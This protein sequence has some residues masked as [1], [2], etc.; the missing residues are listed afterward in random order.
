MKKRFFLLTIL[1]ALLGIGQAWANTAA[2]NKSGSDVTDGKIV[3]SGNHA[4][5]TMTAE[6]HTIEYVGG[7]THHYSLGNLNKKGTSSRNCIFT[8]QAE[9]GCSIKVT[10]M[11]FGVRGYTPA[12][13]YTGRMKAKFNGNEKSVGNIGTS[14][15]FFDES[16]AEGFDN[17]SVLQIW[18]TESDYD[19]W[20]GEISITY[21][22]TPIDA[23]SVVEPATE[24]VIVSLP[25][26][27]NYVDLTNAFAFANAVPSDFAL[28]YDKSGGV[29]EGTNF[30]ATEAGEYTVKARVAAKENCHEA[31]AWSSDALTITVNR[32]D[33]TL[34]WVDE[35]AINTNMIV[36]AEQKI[37]A[38][39]TSG[40]AVTY[41]SSNTDVMTV[42]AEGNLK[43]VAV[44]E[45]VITASRA[46]DDQYN[47]A[48]PITKTFKVRLKDTPFFLPVDFA[49]ADSCAVPVNEEAAIELSYVS[50]GLDGDFTATP[51]D[52]NVISVSRDGNRLNI[53]PLK[54]GKTT[55][56][57]S[58]KENSDLYGLTKTYTI[59][60]IQIVNTIK[61]NGELSYSTSINPSKSIAIVLSSNNTDLEPATIVAEQIEGE[62]IAVLTDG[63][64]YA[65]YRE[66]TATW[67]VTQAESENY[68]KAE[69]TFTITVAKAAEDDTKIL[70][71]YESEANDDGW[72]CSEFG[73]HSWG[74]EGV[75]DRVYFE[76]KKNSIWGRTI[77]AQQL[78]DGTWIT[79]ESAVG[80]SLERNNFKPFNKELD[81][82]ATS[83]QFVAS[84]D[85]DI[86]VRNVKVGVKGHILVDKLAFEAFPGEAKDGQL[87]VR[88]GIKNGGDLQIVCD[89]DKFTLDSYSIADVDGKVGSVNIPIH[90]AAQEVE[91]DEVANI[92]IYNGVYNTAITVTAK[93]RK[94][95][96]VITLENVALTYGEAPKDIEATVDQDVTILYEVTEGTDVVEYKDGQLIAL[97]AGNAKV[98]AYTE[99]TTKFNDSEKIVDV[100]VAKAAPEIKS[101]P[102]A[103]TIKLGQK[104]SESQL[105]GGEASVEGTFSWEDSS[106][107]PESVG[108]QKYNVVFTPTDTENY[109]TVTVEVEILV[110]DKATG[111][112]EL[113]TG[114]KAVKVIRN[115]QVLILREGK[116]YNLS[117]QVV[118]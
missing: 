47:A 55:L 50:D 94:I 30:Y 23:P 49:S 108:T 19:F 43:A 81:A 39:S 105:Q 95:T 97:K 92:I 7:P 111:Y 72:K 113:Q 79:A 42:D 9:N 114:V 12:A 112:E 57:L 88:Y 115:G 110:E 109:E 96:P 107:E 10:K 118:E 74:Y 84:D 33:Q 77:T 87:T 85:G 54:V 17:G 106:I 89:N 61:V 80:G 64:V 69:T 100:T 45:A 2:T 27:R 40:R 91:C 71:I 16:K 62:N 82:K 1:S 75:A 117:G 29:I 37:A 83:I 58:Q 13:W 44:G 38:V 46:Q 25:D 66:G 59:N 65:N 3:I 14:L 24:T 36:D 63:V 102:T 93:V 70:Y 21:T 8:W 56:T 20:I 52:G 11:K 48:E 41:T 5:F 101:N 53:L 34:S 103:E 76:A 90:F 15:T 99:G 78:V 98:R 31:S 28:E 26:N 68:F 73:E 60:V 51:A 32:L 116:I 4:T 35:V 86:R 6:G 67:K 104:L 18:V 22:I